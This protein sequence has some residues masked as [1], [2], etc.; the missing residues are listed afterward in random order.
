VSR[1]LLAALA[2]VTQRR[3]EMMRVYAVDRVAAALNVPMLRDI[4]E[5]T[6]NPTLD[7]DVLALA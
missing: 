1:C 4:P 6:H 3:D 5:H 7:V 2:R